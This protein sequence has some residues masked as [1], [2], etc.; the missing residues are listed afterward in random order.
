MPKLLQVH[1][2]YP[3]PFGN[4][5]S[6]QLQA[7]AASINQE[8][9]FIWKIWTENPRRQ[10]AGGVYLFADEESA[11]AYLR[12][13]SARLKALGVSEVSS[14][15]FDVNPALSQINHADFVCGPVSG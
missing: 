11:Q 7:L 4:D 5:M 3:G 1:F 13:H 12:M 10:E 6:A 9:G 14:R 2:D 8:P 15:I